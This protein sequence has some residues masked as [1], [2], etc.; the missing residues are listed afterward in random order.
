M[1]IVVKI[2]D[3][4]FEMLKEKMPMPSWIQS[5]VLNAVASGTP[6]PKG[7][8]RLIDADKLESRTRL[9]APRENEGLLMR[10]DDLQ[11]APTVVEADKEV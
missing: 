11:S 3:A 2:P 7:H 4:A 8:G 6:L 9:Y 1:E 5:N 10:Y